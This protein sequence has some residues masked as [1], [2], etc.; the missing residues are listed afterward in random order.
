MV[1]QLALFSAIQHESYPLAV[2]TL[3]I[4]S[5][6]RPRLF[7]NYTAVCKPNPTLQ[8]EKVNAK[9]QLVEQTRIK[10]LTEIP[11]SDLVGEREVDRHYLE[12]LNNEQIP[13]FDHN[14]FIKK[15][16]EDN[17]TSW[18]LQISDIPAAGSNR[19][20]ST[21]TIQESSIQSSRGSVSS[22]IDELGYV[23]DY[24]FINIG[25]K[26]QF[27][28]G[29]VLEIFKTWQIIKQ[30]G[31][32]QTKLIT[33][34]GF[35]VKALYNVN[36]ATDIESLNHGTRHLL[37]LKSELGDYINLEIPERK[38]MDSRLNHLH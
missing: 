10:L 22:F 9:N 25:V 1:L 21:Q 26:F 35:M 4:L 16:K 11:L 2:D 23:D 8:I 19:K 7:S 32:L 20:V 38:C 17:N 29:V 37:K 18:S 24:Q 36:K 30:D 5:S 28:T 3:T 27:S 14:S 31:S 13:S 33:K 6:N 12:K 15:I 34:D